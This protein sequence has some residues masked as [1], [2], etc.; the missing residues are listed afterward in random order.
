MRYNYRIHL[1]ALGKLLLHRGICLHLMSTE[2]RLSLVGRQV[3]WNC[4]VNIGV[5]IGYSMTILSDLN[6]CLINRH[7]SIVQ[8]HY[9]EMVIKIH[10]EPLI[11]YWFMA[12]AWFILSTMLHCCIYLNS[13]VFNKW[14]WRRSIVHRSLSN[15]HVRRTSKEEIKSIFE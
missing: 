9:S 11:S 7:D 8:Q 13:A 10:L 4:E 6:L 5:D 2:C 3:N 1:A 14:T 15:E 12:S